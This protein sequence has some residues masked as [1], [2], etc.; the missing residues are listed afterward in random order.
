M[1]VD[2]EKLGYLGSGDHMMLETS[3]AGPAREEDSMELV[4]D[5]QKADMEGLKQAV[6]EINW[7]E[8]F[9]DKTG[10]ECMEV[11]YKVLERETERHV[12]IKLRRSS[13]KPIWMN[14]NIIR[15]I[16]K[17][18]RLWRWYSTDGGRD[19]TH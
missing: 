4:P 13:Q 3:I 18:K 17:K 5:W 2:I 12:P 19:Y 9:G 10:K 1:V 15:P 14:R 11:M 16:G 6:A 8:E 7:T